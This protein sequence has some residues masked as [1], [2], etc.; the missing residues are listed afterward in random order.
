M[1]RK[2]YPPFLLTDR[3]GD[4]LVRA[5][6][7]RGVPVEHIEDEFFAFDPYT[8]KKNKNP[9]R[10][11]E[12]RLRE[13]ARA[14]YIRIVR[15]HDG[16]RRRQLVVV[17]NRINKVEHDGHVI[18][19]RAHARRAPVRFGAHHV[20][21]LDAL[22]D[23]R[24]AIE[25]NGGRVLSVKLDGDLRARERRG[26]RT[27]YGDSYEPIPDAVIKVAMPDQAVREIAVEYVTSKYTDADIRKKHEAFA[28]YDGAIWIGDRE[29]TAERV[30]ALTGAKCSVLS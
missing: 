30:R 9:R 28:K 21:T 22:V 4:I 11:C 25:R 16:E 7:L 10:A 24:R 29:R 23:V 17:E 27:V 6:N 19:N 3:D 15:E 13:L 2:P 26:R 5:S 1:P 8:K 12:R 20:R 18:A 14:G